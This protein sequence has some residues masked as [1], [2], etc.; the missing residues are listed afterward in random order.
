MKALGKLPPAERPAV[1]EAANRAKSSIERAV[2]E[3]LRGARRGEPVGR[4]GARRRRHAAGAR[5]RARDA[6]PADARAPRD[7]DDLPGP[8]LRGAHRPV[9][10]DASGTTSTRSTRRPTTPRATCRTRSSSR[11]A[12]P[13]LAH[14]AGADPHHAGG[15]AAD[16]DRR[17]RQRLPPRRRRHAH[18]DV[19]ADG[20]AAGRQGRVVRRPQGDAAALRPPLLR[21]EPGHAP[22]PQLLPVHGAV[23]RGRRRLLPLRG[24]RPG[25]RAGLPPVQGQ[26]LDRD[27]RRRHGA[28]Q[29]VPR[30]RLRPRRR[31]PASRSAWG[32]RGWR[33]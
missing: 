21:T 29:R 14:L 3:R 1:G 16:P 31:S 18:A 25:G 26:R 33:C 2:T 30:G 24:Q 28:P 15:A 10:R 20:G 27:R 19:P 11:G 8:R 4:P 13:A 17:A 12:H 32:C 9:D 6:A 23:G 5:R 22:A 7:R